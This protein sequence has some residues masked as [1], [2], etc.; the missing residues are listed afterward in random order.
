MRLHVP[1]CT[2]TLYIFSHPTHRM[3]NTMLPGSIPENKYKNKTPTLAF[4]QMELINA[5][6]DVCKEMGVPDHEAFATVDLYEEQ[7]LHQVVVCIQSLGRKVSS[8]CYCCEWQLWL[9]NN[10]SCADDCVRG[11]H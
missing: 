4:M 11:A 1:T 3:A 9:C 7:N 2:F 5:F 6:I 10:A 8:C